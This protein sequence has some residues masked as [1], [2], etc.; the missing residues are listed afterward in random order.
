VPFHHDANRDRM[1]DVDGRELTCVH[2]AG[3]GY[4]TM[5][6]PEIFLKYRTLGMTDSERKQYCRSFNYLRFRVNVKNR[7]LKFKPA[8]K[9]IELRAQRKRS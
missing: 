1:L 6:R 2:W 9:L 4:P 3:C 7:L 8:A 5:V